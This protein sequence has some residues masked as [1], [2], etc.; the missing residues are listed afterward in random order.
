MR[1]VLIRHGR[2]EA[3]EQRLYCGSTDIGLSEAGRNQ[4]LECKRTLDYPDIK[5]LRKI[6]SGMRRTDETMR[7][8]FDSEPEL[9][10]GCLREMNFGRFE[11]H[12][13]DQLCSDS[14]YQAWICDETGD[15]PTPGGESANG[16]Q[17]RIIEAASRI[18]EDA[19]VVCHGGV[20]AALMAHWFP[21]EGKNMYQWQPEG[22]CGYVVDFQGDELRWRSIA[23]KGS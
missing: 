23:L 1:L 14:D 16:F 22:G 13:Y 7:I 5:G 15:F 19:L 20:I 4:L 11:M 10:M 12:S 17:R 21:G 18:S 3:N 8:L 9:R 2:T 6:T